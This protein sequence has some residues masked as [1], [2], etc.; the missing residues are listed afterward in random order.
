MHVTTSANVPS[1][2][3]RWWAAALCVVLVAAVAITLPHGSRPLP[4]VAA[5]LPVYLTLASTGDVFTAFLLL[6]QF[7]AGGSRPLALLAVGYT[8]TAVI[9]VAQAVAF[10]GLFSPNGLFGAHAQTAVWLWT[11]WHGAFPTFVLL[12]ALARRSTS[13]RFAIRPASAAAAVFAVGVAIGLIAAAIAYTAPLPVLVEGNSYVGG[14]GG[15]WQTVIGLALAALV[16][17]VA[18]TRLTTVL[19]LWLAVVL[20]GSLCDIVLTIFAHERFSVGW[21]LARVF[22][23]ITS[24]TVALVFVAELSRLYQRFARLASV[25]ALTGLANRRTFDERSDEERRA[26]ARTGEPYALVMI[27]VDDFKRYNDTY[28]HVA[29]D[30]TLRA[31][32]QAI[33]SVVHRPRDLVARFGGEEFAVLLGSTA[34]DD[35]VVVAERIRAAVAARRIPHRASR[36]APF[37]TIS[38]GVAV[39]FGEDADPTALIERADA[40]LYRAKAAGRNGVA[41]NEAPVTAVEA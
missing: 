11:I 16:A 10:P 8:F 18:L 19:D 4:V 24:L 17:T 41:G 5:F 31:V 2:A 37:V 21:Y 6:V 29:G 39:G 15:T 22:A 13:E 40:A 23:V 36:A 7:R 33:E 28:G 35:A 38:L 1:R 3:E 32:A 34:F 25:D 20:V 30:A 9:A 12:Y 27:D 26:A 14:F